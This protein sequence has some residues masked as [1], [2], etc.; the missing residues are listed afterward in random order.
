MN[1]L[2]FASKSPDIRPTVFFLSRLH[3]LLHSYTSSL[4]DSRP[5]F[6]MWVSAL[7]CQYTVKS[8][9]SY[10]QA[11]KKMCLTTD[12]HREKD[13]RKRLLSTA[14]VL[15]HLH[16]TGH[17]EPFTVFPV[18]KLVLN[19]KTLKAI[20]T[21]SEGAFSPEVGIKREKIIHCCILV[22]F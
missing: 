5:N 17:H 3:S 7:V 11:Q 15:L 8:R 13:K 16:S 14:A 18:V 1:P 9:Q 4:S 6:R 10:L 12:K 20:S 21:F 2:R 22:Y 19:A